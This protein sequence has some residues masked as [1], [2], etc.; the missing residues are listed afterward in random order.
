MGESGMNDC[1]GWDLGG[2]HLKAV[3]VRDG[4][5][6]RVWQV[7]CPLWQGT[8][9]LM[10]ALQ[11]L[12]TLLPSRCRHG[13]TMTGE[14]VDLFPSRHEGVKVIL[15]TFKSLI[16]NEDPR[17][18]M[19]SQLIPLSILTNKNYNKIASN[20]WQ[21]TQHWLAQ[22]CPDTL[23]VD[24]GSTTTDLAPI[25]SSQPA[26]LGSDD[27][28]RMRHGELLYMG[29]LRTPLMALAGQVPF[30][31][32]WVPLMAEH[33]ASTADVY[34]ILGQLPAHIDQGE[35]ADGGPKTGSASIVRLAR[36]VGADREDAPDEAWQ[37]LAAGIREI[38]LQRLTSGCMRLLSRTHQKLTTL[39]G[40]GVGR[41]LMPEVARR[42]ELTYYDFGD[43]LIGAE[44]EHGDFSPADC[45]P[46]A[47]LALLLD[48]HFRQ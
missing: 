14:M 42:L 45:A 48:L 32:E 24:I 1:V 22:Q 4:R 29:V 12:L 34:R 20:N 41:F 38:Q 17:I 16:A 3:W 18:F 43:H 40:A 19:G 5:V 6:L 26:C 44:V 15:K 33:F 35:T 13:L 28:S 21:I 31:G 27:H 36:M 37:R 30:E 23:L 25:V 2:A 47:A 8:D 7:P 46:A 39:V 11:S 9:R 10:E